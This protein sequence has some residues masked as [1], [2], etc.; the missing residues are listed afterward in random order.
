[1]KHLAD[2]I[3]EISD[4][5]KSTFCVTGPDSLQNMTGNTEFDELTAIIK[6]YMGDDYEPEYIKIM[7]IAPER[8]MYVIQE[9]K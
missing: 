6:K 5:F 2:Y 8:N 1:M 7:D 9:K 4:D 3:E